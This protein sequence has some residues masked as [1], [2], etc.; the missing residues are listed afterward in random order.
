M[1]RQIEDAIEA[2][3]ELKAL[4]GICGKAAALVYRVTRTKVVKNGLSGTWLGHPLHPALSDLPI[5]AWVM[6]SALDATAGTTGARAARRLVGLGLIA[7]VPTAAA[8]ASDW[9]DTYGPT[10]RAGYVHAVSNTVGT[11]LQAASWLARRRGYHGAGAALSGTGLAIT[12]CAAYL[13]GHLSFVRGVGVNH[14]AFQEPVT[15]WTE[16]APLSALSDDTPLKV[17]AGSVPVVLA[18]HDGEIYALSS[19]CTHAGGPLDKGTVDRDGCIRC[20]WHGSLFRLADGK[21][22]RGPASVGEP[23][24]DVKI[25]NARVYVRSATA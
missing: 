3:G 1:P 13:G 20:P 24:W 10:Q 18:R 22:L 5:G 16:V 7:A 15:E 21:A 12:L 11:A 9:S 19:T 2:I 17:T 6:A 25:D 14:A 4:D 23:C 8:G